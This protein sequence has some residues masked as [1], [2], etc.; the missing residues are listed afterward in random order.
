MPNW[1]RSLSKCA[2]TK[3]DREIFDEVS[4]AIDDAIRREKQPLNSLPSFKVTIFGDAVAVYNEVEIPALGLALDHAAAK[5]LVSPEKRRDDV[6]SASTA[7]CMSSYLN[8]TPSQYRRV[9]F[10]ELVHAA[11]IRRAR[12]RKD[13]DFDRMTDADVVGGVTD[14]SLPM[15][16]ST[17]VEPDQGSLHVEFHV[18]MLQ[19]ADQAISKWK[20]MVSNGLDSKIAENSVVHAMKERLAN[21]MKSI[22]LPKKTLSEDARW[23]SVLKPAMD[24]HRISRDSIAH[25]KK[26]RISDRVFEMLLDRYITRCESLI[27]SSVR[28]LS[29]TRRK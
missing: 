15:A 23:W 5:H 11:Q 13:L 3:G 10:H 21:S 26:Y 24:F 9:L 12:M 16:M 18:T 1:Y 28:A 19:N 6:R 2:Q 25:Q 29:Q 22:R 4:R 7:V 8:N 14:R 20:E 17:S 27:R